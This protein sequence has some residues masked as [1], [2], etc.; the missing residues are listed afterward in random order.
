[1]SA[2][3]ISYMVEYK[4]ILKEL[5]GLQQEI[6]KLRNT[7]KPRIQTLTKEKVKYEK[8]ILEYL[9]KQ[10]DPGIKFQDITFYRDN[11]RKY[12]DRQ[13]KE[14]QIE[15]LLRTKNLEDELISQV[16]DMLKS[17]KVIDRDQFILRL[18]KHA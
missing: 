14:K 11:K 6:I 18:K 9:E 10:Q 4:N 13:T 3:V 5:N 1:M 8:I 12:I 7:L 16:K 15:N 2:E 17:K